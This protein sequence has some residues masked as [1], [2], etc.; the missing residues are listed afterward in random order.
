MRL[1]NR[2]APTYSRSLPL[3]FPHVKRTDTGTYAYSVVLATFA[4]QVAVTM[5]N[6]TLPTI[7]PKLAEALRI[8]PALIGYQV[9]ILFGAAVVG[10]L[11]G[12]SSTARFGACRTMQLS[13]AL[14]IAGLGL[15]A[16]PSIVAIVAGSLIA[17]FGQGL[18]NSGTADLLV[19]YTPGERRNLFFSIKQS[20]VPFGG[21]LVALA[22]PA[23]AIAL[24]WQWAVVLVA[25]A[26]SIVLVS[27]Q[28]VRNAWDADRHTGGNAPKQKFG[29]VSYVM[30]RPSLRWISLAG[31]L[32]AAVQRSLLTFTVIYLVAERG[33]TLIEAG[34]MLS[35]VQVGGVLGRLAWGWVA[36]R[37][38]STSVL[39]IIAVIT[40]L[41]SFLLMA[42]QAD[43]P[44]A[45]VFSVFFVFGAAAL[46]WNGVLHAEIASL[47]PPGM[48]GVV[49][50]GSTFFVF[51]GVLLGPS[52]FALLYAAIGSYSATFVS[53]AIASV[54]GG[55]LV[56]VARRDAHAVRAAG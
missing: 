4:T 3:R 40:A 14:C 53:L 49:A 11:F 12:G 56:L 13:I 29:G 24:G 18:L 35:V 34:V 27:L 46:G 10:T 25:G 15:M 51:A 44:R 19:R 41:D 22:T 20:G 54:L 17:G 9:S 55:A 47:S 38:S 16:V 23:V 2:E 1:R 43:W 52:L 31:L 26:I 21:M 5:S 8:D 50:G 36:D 7:A 32:F 45:A 6:S 48:V 33:Y 39:L 42:L 37:Y 28:P 30:A